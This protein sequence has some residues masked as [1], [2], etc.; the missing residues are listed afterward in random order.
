M[1]DDEKAKA[2]KLAAAKKRV[3]MPSI[4]SRLIYRLAVNIHLTPSI[5]S[6]N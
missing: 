3:S 1:P 2:E 6:N 4:Y 5:R